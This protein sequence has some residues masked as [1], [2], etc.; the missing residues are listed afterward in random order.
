MH[1]NERI[2]MRIGNISRQSFGFFYFPNSIEDK[3]E[4]RAKLN[5]LSS[6]HLARFS[7]M[8]EGR[9]FEGYIHLSMDKNLNCKIFSNKNITWPEDGSYVSDFNPPTR[10]TVHGNEMYFPSY[11]LSIVRDDSDKKYTYYKVIYDSKPVDSDLS[12]DEYSPRY[13]GLAVSTLNRTL[14]PWVA[15]QI[16]DQED[17]SECINH[18]LS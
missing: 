9:D 4:M 3:R 18:L 13:F 1:K 2:N 16:R 5:R 17:R 15:A 7:D 12:K 11:H 14:A 8:R 6:D 10:F